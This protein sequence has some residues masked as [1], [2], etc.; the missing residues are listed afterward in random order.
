MPPALS[1]SL[2]R[3]A[4]ALLLL[5]G[6]FTNFARLL[7]VPPGILGD[8]AR[9]GL[10][11]FDFLQDG[12]WPGYVYHLFGPQPLILYLQA[13][14][15]VV[16]GF[17]L[18][19]LRGVTA[20]ASA[21][22]VPMLFIAAQEI[23]PDRPLARRA[24]LIAAL[25]FALSPFWTQ[26]AH[27][28]TE[29][30]LVPLLELLTAA[31]LWRGVRRR[32]W[33]AV[34][35]AGLCLG[36]SQYAYI[37]ARF[38]PIALGAACLLALRAEPALLRRWRN[39]ALAAMTAALVALPQWLLFVAE[40]YTFSAR[41]E[42]LAGRPLWAVP[43]AGAILPQKLIAQLLM[44]GV[45]WDSGLTGR[46]MLNV[47]LFGGLLIAVLAILYRRRAADVFVGGMAALLLVPDLL[48]YE[49]L[50]PAV[51]R[52]SVAVPFIFLLAG[53]GCA[54]LWARLQDYLPRSWALVIVLGS[55][56]VAASEE[57]WSFASQVLPQIAQMEG[58][59][60]RTSLVEIAEAD[61]LAAHSAEKLLI[62]TSEIYRAPL[63]F[64]LAERYP[65][66]TGGYPIPLLPGEDVRVLEPAAPD[67]PTTEG[68]AAGYVADEWVLLAHGQMYFM[69]PTP[70]GIR[71][72]DEGTMLLASNGAPAA[73]AYWAQ[74]TG[75][76]A[77]FTPLKVAFQNGLTLVGYHASDFVPGRPLT[78]TL[79]WECQRR[80]DH[81][82]EL[83]T[84]VLTPEGA[85][86]VGIHAWPLHGAYRVRA[87]APGEI[88]PTSYTFDI[89]ADTPP[90]VY[91]L[92][93]GVFHL[94]RRERIP[95]VNGP[96]ML[97]VTAFRLSP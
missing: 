21:L 4:P 73:R 7:T 3:R 35:A 37:T 75:V 63:G 57:H 20:F 69:P 15:F 97:E 67:R 62:P 18:A 55:I 24:G 28:G 61:Y 58:L 6:L 38:F 86:F 71:P 42:Q 34:L 10:Y 1:T 70:G 94:T 81:D 53:L 46:P 64:L 80:L 76:P 59:E 50:N 12:L 48:A 54:W 56:L 17:T 11:T 51:T 29:H 45:R 74:W 39:F 90:G 2:A 8:A 72:S 65:I 19:T 60:W 93:T 40:P 52:L 49:G 25:G 31:L 88:V 30:V 14:A 66:R 44:L 77:P 85:Y 79:F 68:I 33:G 87:W 5:L 9:L 82:V 16:F 43:E 13:P 22:A 32:R 78:V 41:T 84:Q 95:V 47:V 23:I 26:F 92:T 27:N 91:A 89:P 83:F 36:L 96:D